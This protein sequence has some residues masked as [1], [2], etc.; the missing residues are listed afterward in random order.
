MRASDIAD[1]LR[2][3]KRLSDCSNLD[4][5][6]PGSGLAFESPWMVWYWEVVEMRVLYGE[7]AG[8]AETIENHVRTARDKLDRGGSLWQVRC[9][10]KGEEEGKEAEGPTG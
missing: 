8:I 1:V 5:A 4:N 9:R 6:G 10:Q 7:K 3:A 2:Y